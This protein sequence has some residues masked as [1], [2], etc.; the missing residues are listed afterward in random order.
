MA[1]FEP[2]W[3]TECDEDGIETGRTFKAVVIAPEGILFEDGSF[4]TWV[5]Y[6]GMEES[7]L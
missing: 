2:P 3:L 5:E 1:E 4:H 7:E 6:S